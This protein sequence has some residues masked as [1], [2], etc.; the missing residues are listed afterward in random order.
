MSVPRCCEIAGARRDGKSG[1]S[2]F[3]RFS[4]E[5]EV[6]CGQT[7]L[8][9]GSFRLRQVVGF[10]VVLTASAVLARFSQQGDS[11]IPEDLWSDGSL[12]LVASLP[13]DSVEITAALMSHDAVHATEN[14]IWLSKATWARSLD[15]RVGTH[16]GM[17]M[18]PVVQARWVK[19][20]WVK[21]PP[22]HPLALMGLQTGD[23]VVAIQGQL[24]DGPAALSYLYR[25]LRESDDLHFLVEREGTYRCVRVQL[26][27]FKTGPFTTPP[28]NE[29]AAREQGSD[30]GR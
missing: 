26:E 4:G 3:D 12:P 25:V 20:M 10:L 18:K 22:D 19:G 7:S 14:P 13:W 8:S 29:H 11:V 1:G 9:M 30:P 15:Q 2:A 5:E 16:S 21:V 24:I 17:R 6:G 23:V 27:G 28:P